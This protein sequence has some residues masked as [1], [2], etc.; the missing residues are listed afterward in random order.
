M[1]YKNYLVRINK[2]QFILCKGTRLEDDSSLAIVTGWS[3]PLPD[4][5]FAIIDID[6]GLFV[7]RAHRRSSLLNRWKAL[8]DDYHPRI[9]KARGTTIYHGRCMELEKEI[10]VW[11]ESGYLL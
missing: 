5:K 9:E 2:D 11:K 1:K 3:E 6:S 4:F 7:L 8:K 10:E